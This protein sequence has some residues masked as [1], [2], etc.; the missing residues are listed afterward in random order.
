[1]EG[2]SPPATRQETGARRRLP[3]SPPNP[4]STHPLSLSRPP[5]PRP[6]SL[7]PSFPY[8]AALAMAAIYAW[9]T[10]GSAPSLIAG[11]GSS[12]VLGLAGLFSLRAFDQART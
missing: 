5:H 2:L 9:L 7:S 8:A 3:P 1:V 6:L 4:R 10:V 11:G 12:A